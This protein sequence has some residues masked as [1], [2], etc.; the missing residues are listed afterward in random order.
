MFVYHDTPENQRRLSLGICRCASSGPTYDLKSL[1]DKG[2]IKDPHNK[3]VNLN[4]PDVRI[5]RSDPEPE[6]SGYGKT[7]IFAVNSDYEIRIALDSDREV[8]GSVKHETL[9]HNADVLAA[10]EIA[11]H[12]G[13]ITR[14]ND[15]SG[16]Y[17]TDGAL[18][19]KPSFSVAV[20]KAFNLLALPVDPMLREQLEHLTQGL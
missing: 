11:I 7:L 16:S 10:G 1:V 12:D 4:T 8:V 2:R 3:A 18:E 19:A 13:I 6:G 9:F 15:I 5:L 20:L 14:I 17:V